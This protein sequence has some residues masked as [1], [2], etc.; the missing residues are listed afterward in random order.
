MS[1]IASN[2]TMIKQINT[3]LIKSTLKML[4]HSTKPILANE[5]GLSLAT[6]NT[7]LNELLLTGEVIAVELEASNGGRPATRFMYNANFSYIACIYTKT[8]GG[9]NTIAY[10]V[11]DLIGEIIKEDCIILEV[12]NYEIIESVIGD[13]INEFDNIKAVGIGMQGVV[14]NGVVGVC[15]IEELINVPLVDN[16]KKK[17]GIEVTS[18]NDMNFTAY[19]FYMKQNYDMDKSNAI[20]FFPKDNFPG[21]GMIVDGHILRGS[22]NFAGEISF[23]PFDLSREELLSQL[24]N[25]EKFI[26]LV[27]KSIISIISVINPEIIVLTGDLLEEEQ[28]KIIYS[29]CLEIIPEEH[30]PKIL[31]KSNIHEDYINGMISITLETLTSSIKLVNRRL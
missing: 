29:K 17:Y 31:L 9:I 23:L 27:V 22:T 20:L 24:N 10:V 21:S 15:D 28:L 1:K 7:I 5:T 6:C 8:E 14:T 3:A 16:I 30:M 25:R 26:P 19:G 4:K 2:T 12:I 18:N 13:L 11:T